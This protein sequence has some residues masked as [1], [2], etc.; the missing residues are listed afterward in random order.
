MSLIK[1]VAS[2]GAALSIGFG[3]MFLATASGVFAGNGGETCIREYGEVMG[4][5]DQIVDYMVANMAKTIGSGSEGEAK[6]AECRKV[7]ADLAAEPEEYRA[8]IRAGTAIANSM[9]AANPAMLDMIAA[10]AGCGSQTAPVAELPMVPADTGVPSDTITEATA[11]A[12]SNTDSPEELTTLPTDPD[13]G[14]PAAANMAGISGATREDGW[15]SMRQAVELRFVRID[16]TG[17]DM[18]DVVDVVRRSGLSGCGNV[19]AYSYTDPATGEFDI[20]KGALIHCSD[21]VGDALMLGRDGKVYVRPASA[22]KEMFG[23]VYN[24]EI[25]DV[26]VEADRIILTYYE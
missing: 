11:L 17:V 15:V 22:S 25:D 2:V 9:V 13:V 19:R 1:T 5:S 16:M 6:I 3:G 10:N 18:E 14:T 24:A 21:A 23:V 7:V 4:L 20:G 12:G 26:S 8:S